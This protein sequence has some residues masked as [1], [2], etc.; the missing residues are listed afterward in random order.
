MCRETHSHASSAALPIIRMVMKCVRRR[1]VVDGC[2]C[3]HSRLHFISGVHHAPA[4]CLFVV[5]SSEVLFLNLIDPSPS[6]QG[7]HSMA[8]QILAGQF[9]HLLS[10]TTRVY[11]FVHPTLSTQCIHTAVSHNSNNGGPISGH[12]PALFLKLHLQLWRPS[13][14]HVSSLIFSPLSLALLWTKAP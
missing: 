9:P 13:I 5:G 10:S 7:N 8:I 12:Y 11:I 2:G 3:I 14:F 1:A 4:C 6:D